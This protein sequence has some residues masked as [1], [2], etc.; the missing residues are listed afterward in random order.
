MLSLSRNV[1]ESLIIG[2][3]TRITVVRVRGHQ[4]KFLIDAPKEVVVDR[5]EIHEKKMAG[6]PHVKKEK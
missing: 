6:I 2:G 4:V 5:E 3:N 1:G